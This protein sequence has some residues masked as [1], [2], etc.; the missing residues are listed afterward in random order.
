MVSKV[1][2]PDKLT[3][4]GCLY[5]LRANIWHKGQ[6]DAGKR[7][8]R[9]LHLLTII[10]HYYADVVI[11]YKWKRFNDD[12]LSEAYGTSRFQE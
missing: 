6:S 10:G 11:D 3:L 9:L 4:N 12:K 2:L 7:T 1:D 8:N 5:Q